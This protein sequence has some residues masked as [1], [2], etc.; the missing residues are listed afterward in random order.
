MSIISGPRVDNIE[1]LNTIDV[2][3]K[4]NKQIDGVTIL[5]RALVS[6]KYIILVFKGIIPPN[7]NM[8]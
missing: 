5:S 3:N 1:D 4:E 2:F 8:D 6:I 7:Y